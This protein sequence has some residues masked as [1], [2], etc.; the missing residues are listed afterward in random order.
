MNQKEK[1]PLAHSL[2][3]LHKKIDFLQR[4]VR[5]WQQRAEQVE[6]QKQEMFETFM[7]EVRG[8]TVERVRAE[9]DLYTAQAR[10]RSLVN[11]EEKVS[12]VVRL[13]RKL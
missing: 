13:W 8:L 7:N 11:P 1:F 2:L 3:K 9:Q 12:W 6:K 5:Y 4:Q 10:I